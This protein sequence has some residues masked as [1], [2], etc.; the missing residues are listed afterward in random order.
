MA[1]WQG[2]WD[3]KIVHVILQLHPHFGVSEASLLSSLTPGGLLRVGAKKTEA[4]GQTWRGI[5]L[6][7]RANSGMNAWVWAFLQYLLGKG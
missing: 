4:T 3:I 6:V 1:L 2:G 5:H 7:R